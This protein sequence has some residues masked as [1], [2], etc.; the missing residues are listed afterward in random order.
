MLKEWGDWDS[1]IH[2]Q[3][4]QIVCQERAILLK[5]KPDYFQNSKINPP[6][7]KLKSMQLILHSIPI[8]LAD[9]LID[10][11]KEKNQDNWRREQN[12]AL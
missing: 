6:L 1:S 5:K 8:P 10:L 2:G 9:V 7:Q 4:E 11:L 3:P 12:T